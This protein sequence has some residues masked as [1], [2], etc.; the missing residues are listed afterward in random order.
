MAIL[1]RLLRISAS[2]SIR[3]NGPK[4]PTRGIVRRAFGSIPYGMSVDATW[5]KDGQRLL[6][7]ETGFSTL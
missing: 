6:W 3:K 5:S 2:Y 7:V 4:F 1:I